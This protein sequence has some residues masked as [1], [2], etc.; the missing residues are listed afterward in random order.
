MKTDF[1][2]SW[3]RTQ[4]QGLY[5]FRPAG[6]AETSRGKFYSRYT[7]NNRRTFRSLNTDVFEIAKVKHAQKVAEVAVDRVNGVGNNADFKTL[8]A[9]FTE[10][11]NRLDANPVKV[12]TEV[13]R[14]ANM[15]R[16]VENWTAGNFETYL[17]SNVTADVI[18]GLREHLLGRAKW[19]RYRH[20]GP[21]NVGY[22]AP[23][24]NT[25]LWVLRVMLDIAVE[26][27]VIPLSPFA[28]KTAL[29]G[30]LY[31][32][33]RRG[34]N[35]KGALPSRGDMARVFAS[36]RE[37]QGGGALFHDPERRATLER[38]AAEMA[39][40]AELLAYSGMRRDEALA[41]TVA[42]DR[43]DEFKIW[44]TKSAT[45]ERTIPVNPALRQVLDRIKG[46]RS[47]PTSKLCLFYEPRIAVRRACKRLG[48]PA[49]RNHDFR[50][51]FAS[52]CIASGVDIPSVS[53]WLGHADGGALLMRTYGHLLKDASQAAAAKVNFNAPTSQQTAG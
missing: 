5:E 52:V 48:L 34:D 31:A 28:Q 35:L 16:L 51:Y 12:C 42:D 29:R 27:K 40:H 21:T 14:R 18:V 13:G 30:S 8:G 17:A 49:L 7:C 39:D 9:L 26:K 2:P 32:V 43:G 15:A 50:H 22:G 4:V 46:R 3:R 6:L 53:R 47:D 25:A 41:S 45:S 19:R 11:R 10:V 44:G 33:Q 20:V 38:T 24:T 36:M 23:A 37:V 1:K